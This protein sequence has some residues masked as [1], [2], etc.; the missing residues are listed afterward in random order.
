MIWNGI[1]PLPPETEEQTLFELCLMH[2][3]A[4]NPCA[5]QLAQPDPLDLTSLPGLF[6]EEV[7]NRSAGSCARN[8]QQSE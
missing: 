1:R 4:L 6:R 8:G 7:Q 5:P 2:I 3:A